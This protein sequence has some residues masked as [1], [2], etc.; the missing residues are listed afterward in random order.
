[1]ASSIE[2]ARAS[3]DRLSACHRAA[4]Y[5]PE[6]SYPATATSGEHTTRLLRRSGTSDHCSQREGASPFRSGQKPVQHWRARGSSTPEAGPGR[7]HSPLRSAWLKALHSSRREQAPSSVSGEPPDPDGPRPDGSG[8]QTA[9]GRVGIRLHDPTQISH[10][11]WRK[12]TPATLHPRPARRDQARGPALP[13]SGPCGTKPVPSAQS[14][15]PHASG[16][17]GEPPRPSARAVRAWPPR[18]RP[19]PEALCRDKACQPR[20][21]TAKANLRC[22]WRTPP[23]LAATRATVLEGALPL[24]RCH[25]PALS[26]ARASSRSQSCEQ[27]ERRDHEGRCARRHLAGRGASARRPEGGGEPPRSVAPAVQARRSRGS[28]GSEAPC[29]VAE[30]ANQRRDN[31]GEPPVSAPAARAARPRGPQCSEALYR[32]PGA[33]ATRRSHASKLTQTWRR[34]PSG[35]TLRPQCSEA[36]C[37]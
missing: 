16:C 19:P 7:R 22:P 2:L 36:P 20:A 4:F 12:N 15:Q 26:V 30:C 17:R 14:D 10:A 25:S 23:G 31:G 21:E 34:P 18:G 37:R 1:M 9:H 35:T 6:G 27:S 3:S 13:E 5:A 24:A 29:R 8:D 11:Q 28:S 32:W 33:P